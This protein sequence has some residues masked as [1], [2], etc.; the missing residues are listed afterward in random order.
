MTAVRLEPDADS[1]RLV[2]VAGLHRSGTTPL[3][4]LLAGHPDVSGFA[5]S[6]VKEDEGQHL[7]D[8]YPSARAYGGAGR[9]ALDPRARLTE[10]APLVGTDNARR[11]LAAWEPY[12]NL[13]RR[14]LVEKSPPNLVMTRFL[15]A[16][17]PHARFVV[18]VRHPA[19]VTL[20]TKRW[21]GPTTMTKLLEHWV[22]A[23]EVFCADVAALPDGMRRVHVVRYEQLVID[24]ARTMRGLADF[25]G[26]ADPPSTQSFDPR[27]SD[28]YQ[29]RWAALRTEGPRWRR[30][31]M[32]HTVRRFAAPVGALGYDL[33]DLS[34]EGALPLPRSRT[35]GAVGNAE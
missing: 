23:H 15:S 33:V 17:F 25:L 2:F 31:W 11:L 14:L 34:W 18:I 22:R 1:S 16:L 29:A 13:D 12:W 3:A 27:R 32:A 8:V 10:S 21:S 35:N 30:A 5:A 9:F 19:V 28:T 20:S 7:Q 4:R 24:P 6:G 26:L